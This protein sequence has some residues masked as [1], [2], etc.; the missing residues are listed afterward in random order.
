[1]SKPRTQLQSDLEDIIGSRN[2]YFQPPESLKMSFPAI[3][4]SLSSIDNVFS[5]D[6]IYRRYNVYEII[7][8]DKNPESLFV[9][10]ILGLPYCRFV[11]SYKADNLNHYV[12]NIYF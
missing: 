4:Y 1:M 8:I 12:F 7:L 5:S 6:S 10:R 2:V 3:V 9:D 11:R